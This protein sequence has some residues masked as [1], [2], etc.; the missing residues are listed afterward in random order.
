MSRSPSPRGG[1]TAQ[2]GVLACYEE[3]PERL[4]CGSLTCTHRWHLPALFLG[5]LC[6]GLAT[7]SPSQPLHRPPASLRSAHSLLCSPGLPLGLRKWG[8]KASIIAKDTPGQRQ[9]RERKKVIYSCR[10]H[11]HVCIFPSD[12]D[13]CHIIFMSF[14][15]LNSWKP[16]KTVDEKDFF[17]VFIYSSRG[18]PVASLVAQTVKRLPAM[19]E[20][21]G[22]RK[23]P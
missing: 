10:P 19:W 12:T 7:V 5:F 14:C 21:Q 17:L 15:Y 9:I 4:G 1:P 20:T 2:F 16:P 3:A 18:F 6:R 8:E 23:T 22:V 11:V 13:F